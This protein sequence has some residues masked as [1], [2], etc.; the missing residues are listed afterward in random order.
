MFL[1]DSGDRIRSLHIA[2]LSIHSSPIGPLGTQDSGGMSVYIRELA[3]WLGKSGH[4]IDIF[5]YVPG[6]DQFLYPNVRLI[7]LAPEKFFNLIFTFFSYLEL[8]QFC[9]GF[10]S[11]CDKT[12][13][14]L[15]KS[16]ECI[17]VLECSNSFFLTEKSF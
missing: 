9:V 13:E 7:H 5:T 8:L 14:N 17:D 6:K 15:L 10:P 1:D 3:R 11:S 4:R 2:M 12:K 16:A